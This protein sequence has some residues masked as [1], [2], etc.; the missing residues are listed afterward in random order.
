[1]KNRANNA[2]EKLVVGIVA[3]AM[4]VMVCGLA[5]T[6]E[7]KPKAGL[8][9]FYGAKVDSDVWTD[10]YSWSQTYGFFVDLPIAATF[11]ITPTASNYWRDGAS[12]TDL[13][14]NFKFIIPLRRFRP[15]GG[16]L[17]GLSTGDMKKSDGTDAE[18][19]AFHVGAN[20]GTYIKII[21]NLEAIVEVA[22]KQFTYSGVDA[23]TVHGHI[24]LCIR[25]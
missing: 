1:M 3:V 25:L 17:A 16:I 6:V 15:Y 9:L 7:A 23:G 19:Y 11:H 4:A 21:A 14:A 18:D 20:V 12:I 5:P 24:G 22:Y 2:T 8:G 13:S 10:K